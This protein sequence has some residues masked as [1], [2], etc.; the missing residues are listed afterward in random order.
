VSS[1]G[2]MPVDQWKSMMITSFYLCLLI[3]NICDDIRVSWT[4][5]I[6]SFYIKIQHLGNWI[7]SVFRRAWVMKPILRRQLKRIHL[8]H[9]AP[10]TKSNGVYYTPKRGRRRPYN[11]SRNSWRWKQIQ[12][13]KRCGFIS[14]PKTMKEVQDIETLSLF[15]EGKWAQ[16]Q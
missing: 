15:V 1:S 5:S 16:N 7:L 10:N 12:F 11:I 8:E 2:M 6:V 3:M 14:K 13:P 9:W 4:L